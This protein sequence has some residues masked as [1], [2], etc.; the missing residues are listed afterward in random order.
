[1]DPARLNHAC[2]ANCSWCTVGDMLFVRCQREVASGEEL[3]IPYCN[4]TDAVEDR[5]DFL[6]G[7]HGFVCCCGL[8][9]AQ[10]SAEAYNRDVA[11]A[12]A[13][14]ARGDWE[15]SLVHHTA[16]FKFL[17][18]REYC[19]QRQTQLEHCMAANAACHRLRQAKSAHFWLQEAR[20]S[21]ALQWGDD[22]EAF[23]LYA[24]QCGALGADFG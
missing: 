13:C 7:R 18:S 11:L 3:T 4:P 15:A 6:K 21:F 12:E 8:C 24:E 17:A 10:K 22:P 2:D 14:E 5:R 16:A 20:K 9:E 1:M 23:R 19:S